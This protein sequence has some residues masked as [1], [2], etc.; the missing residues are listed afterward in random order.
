MTKKRILSLD[1]GVR[2]LGMALSDDLQITAQPYENIRFKGNAEIQKAF[3]ALFNTLKEY[4]IETIVIGFPLNMNGTEG[5]QSQITIDFVE[6]FQKHMQKKGLNP[7]DWNWEYWDER[8]STAAASR[9]LIEA[10]VSRKKRKEV[11]DKM[12]AVHILQGYLESLTQPE[13]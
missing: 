6:R 9:H 8:L 7:D 2:S 3:L 13:W 5:P 12:A 1:I 4:D 10:D 11:I